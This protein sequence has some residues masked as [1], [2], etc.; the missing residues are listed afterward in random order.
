MGQSL[1]RD[2]QNLVFCL[3]EVFLNS[4]LFIVFYLSCVL[5]NTCATALMQKLEDN[6]HS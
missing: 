3:C 1:V 2:F 6:L 5:G 4:N